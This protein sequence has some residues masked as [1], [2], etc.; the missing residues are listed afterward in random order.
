MTDGREKAEATQHQLNVPMGIE[1]IPDYMLDEA[2]EKSVYLYSIDDVEH[3]IDYVPGLG[4]VLIPACEPGQP[5]SKPYI[6]AGTVWEHFDIGDGKKMTRS[7]P[8]RPQTSRLT[9]R[10]TPGVIEDILQTSSPRGMYSG[11]LLQWGVF[12]AAGKVPTKQ[13]LEAA[14]KE[15]IETAKMYVKNADALALEGD[16][17]KVQIHDLHRRMCIF[18]GWKK[19]WLDQE[20]AELDQCPLCAEGIKKGTA[21]CPHCRQ[22][23]DKTGLDA[24]YGRVP[25]LATK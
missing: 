22:R 6:V 2:H 15:K 7:A 1:E 19:N 13:E 21:M 25:Q 12:A 16:R 20:T 18:L 3:A 11:N 24:F 9:G 5:Y 8:A 23:I 4:R 17:G 14:K 10:K